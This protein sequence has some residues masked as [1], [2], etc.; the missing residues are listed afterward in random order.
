[1]DQQNKNNQSKNEKNEQKPQQND[2]LILPKMPTQPKMPKE[3]KRP[4]IMRMQTGKD[5]MN[6]EGMAEESEFKDK[7]SEA[8]KE[9]L[10]LQ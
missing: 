10:L 3:P 8:V 4:M 2:E 1:M 7:V 6:F 9:V 5:G